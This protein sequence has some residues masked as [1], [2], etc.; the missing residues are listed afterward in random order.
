MQFSDPLPGNLPPDLPVLTPSFHSV[1]AQIPRPLGITKDSVSPERFDLI[2]FSGVAFQETIRPAIRGG[3][4]FLKRVIINTSGFA[5]YMVS[6]ASAKLCHYSM[7]IA[8][9][10]KNEWTWLYS[11]T[12]LFK[13]QAEVR[14]DLRA[15]FC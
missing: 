2:A 3:K 15:I 4:L 7:K 1:P 8:I 12:T 9:D 14:F 10:N 13:R 6:F 5:G 11:N